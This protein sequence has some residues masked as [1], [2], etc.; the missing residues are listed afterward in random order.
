SQEPRLL[1]ELSAVSPSGSLRQSVLAPA[2]AHQGFPG[3]RPDPHPGR[4]QGG[5][6]IPPNLFPPRPPK[7]ASWTIRGTHFGVRVNRSSGARQKSL[8]E[9]V[10]RKIEHDIES[11][12]LTG[13]TA[14]GFVAA[15]AAYMKAGG[16]TRFRRPLILH[17]GD[18]R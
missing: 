11:G 15:A 6:A 7:N 9:K 1:A 8:A 17:L 3:R 5:P 10:R 12:A 16:D 18:P 14:A 13:K 2:R 4:V